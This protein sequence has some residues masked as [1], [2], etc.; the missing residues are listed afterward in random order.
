MNSASWKARLDVFLHKIKAAPLNTIRYFVFWGSTLLAAMHII[1]PA[2]YVITLIIH[3]VLCLA[4]MR[5]YR[6]NEKIA[7]SNKY[8]MIGSL[9]AIILTTINWVMLLNEGFPYSYIRWW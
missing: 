5:L 6:T 7:T 2:T 8:W 1:G 4:C 9:I 3:A